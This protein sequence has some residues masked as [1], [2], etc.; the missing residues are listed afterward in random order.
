M[1]ENAERVKMLA[2]LPGYLHARSAW[3]AN[4]ALLTHV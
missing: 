4:H 3:I 2:S 1:N